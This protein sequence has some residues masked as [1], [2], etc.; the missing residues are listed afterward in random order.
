MRHTN[1]DQNCVRDGYRARPKYACT[2]SLSHVLCQRTRNIWLELLCFVPYAVP[3]GAAV[4]TPSVRLSATDCVS[5][6]V[7]VCM[8]IWTNCSVMGCH[9]IRSG[10]TIVNRDTGCELL[11]LPEQGSH[12]SVL[13][14]F[15]TM[16]DTRRWWSPLSC[17]HL[18]RC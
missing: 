4:E 11:A 2:L 6:F 12:G 16:V 3:F 8:C 10:R 1:S 13:S 14:F 7:R 9:G 5:K 15:F 17:A 18:P